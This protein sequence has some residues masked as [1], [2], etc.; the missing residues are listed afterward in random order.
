MSKQRVPFWKRITISTLLF[1]FS[2]SAVS[3]ATPQVA[4][5]QAPVVDLF[6]LADRLEDFIKEGIITA[7][8]VGIKNALRS[9]L[10][11]VAYDTATWIASGD[12]NQKPLLFTKDVGVYLEEAGDAATGEFLN[13]LA[14]KNGLVELNLCDLPEVEKL[15]FKLILPKLLG[16][17][18]YKPQCTFSE[19]KQEFTDFK[20]QAVAFMENPESLFDFSVSLDTGGNALSSLLSATDQ[21][22]GAETAAERAATIQRLKSDAKDKEAKVSEYIQT[23][24][25]VVEAQLEAA[26]DKSTDGETIQQ[27]NI[28]ADAVSVFFNTLSS[29]LME[30][31]TS[32]LL[33]FVTESDIADS[34]S[35]G[36]S[37]AGG[38]G[39][40]KG[41]QEKFASFRKPA[42]TTGGEVD[43]LTH[44]VNCPDVGTDVT[45]CIINENFRIAIE[46]ELTV[47][48]AIAQGLLDPSAI[49][50]GGVPNETIVDDPKSGLSVRALKVLKYYNVV[51]VGWLLA[52]E[53]NRD[54]D[55]TSLT[56]QK[57]L[58]AYDQ[59]DETN[60][61]PYCGLVDGDWV[62]KAPETFC[63]VQGYGE[64]IANEV[65]YEDLDGNK[66]TPAEP[67]LTR[68]TSCLDPQ[69]CLTEDENGSCQ[70]Y[71]YCTKQEDIYRFE[72]DSCPIYAASCEQFRTQ[73]NETVSYLKN[74]LNYND[75]T[76]DN[77]GCQWYCSITDKN[78]NPACIDQDTSYQICNSASGCSCST[79][80]E[81]CTVEEGNFSC[82]TG[83]GAICNLP[84]Q[85]QSGDVDVA[86]SFDRDV[87][88]C[89]EDEEGCTEFVSVK[90]GNM[91]W[92]GSFEHFNSH[93]SATPDAID[94][95]SGV[96]ES[97]TDGPYD[98]T[99]G[100][101][102]ADGNG[103]PCKTRSANG[104]PC[105]GWELGNG[106]DG[107][108]VSSS[109]FGSTGF[110]FEP[111]TSSGTLSTFVETGEPLANRTFSFSFSSL[112]PTSSACT[113]NLFI[114]PKGGTGNATSITYQP[115]T[116][117]TNYPGKIVTFPDSES[118]TAVE[119][120]M[121][122]PTNN[123]NLVID[124][125]TLI[126]STA[127]ASYTDYGA[128]KTYLNVE[129]T[130]QC[131][132]EQIGCELFTPRT[133]ESDIPVPAKITNPYSDVCGNGSDFTNPA[134]SQCTLE[135]LG[136]DAYIESPMPFAAPVNNIA[137]FQAL[138]ITV[139]A[140]VEDA[141]AGRTGLY[142]EGTSN[143][144]SAN[145]D[146]GADSAGNQIQCVPSISII[147]ET[148]TECSAA[149]VG[150]EE[151]VNLEAQAGGGEQLEHYTYIRQCVKPID[152][153]IEY[154]YTFEGSDI[155]GYQIRSWNLKKSNLTTGGPCTNLDLYGPTAQTATANCVDTSSNV[156]ACGIDTPNDASDD[157]GVNPDCNEYF[158][159]SG[160]VFHRLRSATVTV[161]D[162][163]TALR[164]TRDGLTYYVNPA[165]STSCPASAN[166]CREYKGSQGGNV[167]V[168]I[169][170]NFDK[171]VWQGGQSSSDVITAS[172]GQSMAVGTSTQTSS[173][174]AKFTV[175]TKV[176]ANDSYIL[177]F[178]AKRNAAD[179]GNSAVVTPS[180]FSPT[181]ATDKPWQTVTVGTEWQ[182]YNVGPFIFSADKAPEAAEEFRLQYTGSLVVIDNLELQRNSSHYLIQGSSKMCNGFEG[183][184]RYETSTGKTEYLKSFA[185]LCEESAVGCTALFDTQNSN[186]PYYQEF[187]TNNEH[188]IDDVKVS[189]DTPVA[190]VVKKDALCSSE[191]AGCGVYGR[192]DLDAS[193]A[194]QSYEVSYLINDPDSYNTI[195]C[196]EQQRDCEVFTT[197]SGT[198]QYFK[199]PGDKTCSYN[200]SSG[201]WE[202]PDGSE[203]P[204]QNPQDNPSQPKGSVC[205]G[206]TRDAQMCSS[207]ADCPS[208]GSGTIPRCSSSVNDQSGWVGSC[209]PEYAGCSLYMDPNTDSLLENGSFEVD[210]KDNDD[211]VAAAPDGIPDEW[212]PNNEN[213]AEG[214]TTNNFYAASQQ[215]ASSC[216]IA[217]IESTNSLV[218]EGSHSMKLQATG[219][220]CFLFSDLIVIDPNKTY[221]LTG[222]VNVSSSSTPFAIGLI[223]YNTS[224]T[225]LEAGTDTVEDYAI[226]AYEGGS[227][228]SNAVLNQ[229]ARF[230]ANIGPNLNHSF[231]AGANYVRVFIETADTSRPLYA[232][233]VTF[234][235]QKEYTYISSTVDGAPQS[236]QNS[237]NG[238]VDPGNGCVA[239]R[240]TTDTS[241]TS[242]ST[243]ESE[244]ANL[245]ADGTAFALTACQFNSSDP[246]QSCDSRVN[247]ADTNVVIKVR[248][249]R[250]CSEWLS[251]S[252]T[253]VEYDSNGNIASSTC[254][255]VQLCTQRNEDTGVCTEWVAKPAA[256]T[257][258]Y[259]DD[260]T[261][262][263]SPQDT[264][265]LASIRDLS[266]YSN[267]GVEW[268][269]LGCEA[270]FCL[271]GEKHGQ[272]CSTDP[273]C[274]TTAAIMLGYYPADWMPE[275]GLAGGATLTDLIADGDFEQ[276]LCDGSVPTGAYSD[277]E[278]TRDESLFCT[279]DS[280][281][282][283]FE[284]DREAQDMGVGSA[285][286]SEGWCNNV[287]SDGKWSDW[288]RYSASGDPATYLSVI[289][290][291]PDFSY[292]ADVNDGSGVS[293]GG[294]SKI[295]LNNVMY[296]L[297][298]GNAT[299]EGIK[300]DLGTDN[301]IRGEEY[302]ISFDAQYRSQPGETDHITVGFSYGD[303]GE[304]DV[305]EYGQALADIV[306]LIDVSG[307][308][309]AY[310]SSV[311][312]NLSAFAEGLEAQGINARFSIVTI[313][314][315]R[316]PHVLD[317]ADYT[318]ASSAFGASN[319][320]TTAFSSNVTTV[321]DVLTYLTTHLVSGA[322]ENYNAIK[323]VSDNSFAYR[324]VVA[325]SGAASPYSLPFRTEAER[326]AILVTDTVPEGEDP[327]I[328]QG[329]VDTWD[330]ADEDAFN[331]LLSADAL[332]LYAIT[333]SSSKAYDR[334]VAQLGDTS[335]Y[336][337]SDSN[338]N[339]LLAD[340]QTNIVQKTD[341]FQFST[342]YEQYVLG[343]IVVTNKPLTSANTYLYIAQTSGSGNIPFVIDNV[344]LKPALEVNKEGNPNSTRSTWL[345]GQQCRAYPE[346]SS[347]SC[348]YKTPEGVFY[349]GWKGY[350]LDADSSD[351]DKCIAWW[352]V[353]IIAGEENTTS[354]RIP[355]TYDQQVPAYHCLVA[356][357]NAD[358]GVC[359]NADQSGTGNGDGTDTGSGLMCSNNADCASGETCLGKTDSNYSF[360]LGYSAEAPS[361][362]LANL[363]QTLTTHDYKIVH[364]ID[365]I[366]V[367]LDGAQD[368]SENDGNQDY[369]WFGRIPANKLEQSVHISEIDHVTF[370]EGNIYSGSK[371]AP[372]EIGVTGY[373]TMELED[374]DTQ[375]SLW[376]TGQG[377]ETGDATYP[378]NYSYQ[379]GVWCDQ[380]KSTGGFC[381]KSNLTPSSLNNVDFIFSKAVSAAQR[382]DK[383]TIKYS[384]YDELYKQGV[385]YNIFAK[386]SLFNG[387]SLT[388]ETSPIWKCHGEIAE[389]ERDDEQQNNIVDCNN[390]GEWTGSPDF[391]FSSYWN[392]EAQADGG[393][394]DDNKDNCGANIIISRL[395]FDGGYLKNIYFGL[396]N[397]MTHYDVTEWRDVK[398][399]FHLKEP[400]LFLVESAVESNDNVK[401]TPWLS[402][403]NGNG[404]VLPSVNYT[405]Q[406]AH[407][408]GAV[409][410][411]RVFGVFGKTG[412]Y[413]QDEDGDRSNFDSA[414][415][416]YDFTAVA[417]NVP[418]V[419]LRSD[420]TSVT[421]Y[422]CIGSCNAIV[423]EGQPDLEYSKDTASQCDSGEWIGFSGVCSNTDENKNAVVCDSNSDC[424]GFGGTCVG[425]EGTSTASA[426]S[427]D[428][429]EFAALPPPE[430]DESDICNTYS[431]EQKTQ[432]QD[433]FDGDEKACD[434][435]DDPSSAACT[436]TESSTTTGLLSNGGVGNGSYTE[437][438]KAAAQAAWARYRLLFADVQSKVYYAPAS[439][440]TDVKPRLSLQDA[441]TSDFAEI[442]SQDGDSLSDFSEMTQCSVDNQTG[443]NYCGILPEVKDIRVNGFTD[444]QIEVN[445]GSSVTLT[446]DS[447][448]DSDQ[449]PLTTIGLVWEG[450]PTGDFLDEN[451]KQWP[452]EAAPIND[453]TYTHVYTCD[454]TVA[455]NN[456]QADVLTDEQGNKIG[457]CV[458]TIKVQIQDNWGFCSGDDNEG[459][460]GYKNRAVGGDRCTSYDSYSRQIYVRFP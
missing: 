114:Q 384:S 126:E 70:A 397:G 147:P 192:P 138:G 243:T 284:S 454:P 156:K 410:S 42:F 393:C 80:G 176:N 207:D 308:M 116:T 66:N 405:F 400:C 199:N 387:D 92:N 365:T 275:R 197:D 170:D 135:Y 268:E 355:V 446:F 391:H 314:A 236:D 185:S 298:T 71:G 153:E 67:L 319:G 78:G 337:I 422:S 389:P 377:T 44:F 324:D 367:D 404:Y 341:S 53:Y 35:G 117:F 257:L 434:C 282:R 38:S 43:I 181:T 222:H 106:L 318:T 376:K 250:Q 155:S 317:F 420:E 27:D 21:A 244:T 329:T 90:A 65:Q 22:I 198:E 129:K 10:E 264:G 127:I 15:Q 287:N 158:D 200:S 344:S 457:A 259:S 403:V 304:T 166:M 354:T 263:S 195:L 45:N 218:F 325:T 299:E 220:H 279:V 189:V 449:Q 294:T 402:R 145:S 415:D 137:A 16:K 256:E 348:D 238:T 438:L 96:N 340:I 217:S 105:Y 232:D 159:A 458:Y 184:E 62:L 63:R 278:S 177:S 261:I 428:Q 5:A 321:K 87:K 34:L 163:C 332:T 406:L 98:D 46:E 82:S 24:A 125:V 234:T 25:F 265:E 191:F 379:M 366:K 133:G 271:G 345:L 291:D 237:C 101:F 427:T 55:T 413:P 295:N 399:T 215:G 371:K 28:V 342:N 334:T 326:F 210:A 433:C 333:N 286:Y 84:T 164:N 437:Q 173:T 439:D 401:A 425:M 144:C 120:V 435:Y 178:W 450:T 320:I 216:S 416:L 285:D 94:E 351:P 39:G 296:V 227:R 343:P 9:F 186:L 451:P 57:A 239:F 108:A 247:T 93:T 49:I 68:L 131:E 228:S 328:D 115:G 306:L 148:G 443:T 361:T 246:N 313:G 72:G 30:R 233:G 276:V 136:C 182:Q 100:F 373:D 140:Q 254:A 212:S 205:V 142:C 383:T 448:V 47:H 408:N 392:S 175:G 309:G 272:Q 213:V 357:G 146:C 388:S 149:N 8:K 132:V 390:N 269:T 12:K 179:S 349:N 407:P 374:T 91:L 350:C 37:T 394:V 369:A 219:A 235:E 270:G 29:K 109:V 398:W 255:E 423:C 305:F 221:T 150:C 56:L 300:V 444:T 230:S 363:V 162:E 190:Y 193:G 41:A 431:G 134:C 231:P 311:A 85:N 23:P 307:S 3:V 312:A 353:D 429:S 209:A 322:A 33:N 346:S 14:T 194:V 26:I 196:Q 75:C 421:P 330:Q 260:Q 362:T 336:N 409:A 432:C 359:S 187:N 288:S 368:G 445:N 395:D 460:S 83:S 202:K 36:S 224:G 289:D 442:F 266:G 18:P 50:L 154:F 76:T 89:D 104:A 48:Q 229:W 6:A 208:D 59:C 81:S 267:I 77:A 358:L 103:A 118:R 20:D 123:C 31:F 356:K 174:Q 386:G 122:S 172:N 168:V 352:P 226:A 411:N 110:Q 316:E 290:Y 225:E 274:G 161:T 339:Q 88:P 370:H 302:V 19:M 424:A 211:P 297:P 430:E 157:I 203:C 436:G 40:V 102:G 241:L 119:V 292:E 58:A 249:D 167:E 160:N 32:G 338:Y 396:W 303:T 323:Q 331:P 385:P 414:P 74:T 139:T 201:R 141:I 17:E 327:Y 60:Y 79:S 335:I 54:F 281:C 143:S 258:G 315:N 310:I 69:T 7:G 381:S 151:Y 128:T 380:T 251:C 456:Y 280:H 204:V 453:H 293:T 2:I 165:E 418:T 113:N 206:G 111:T 375:Y 64:V 426:Q 262:T 252:N 169:A 301:I 4:Y 452:W 13:S 61:S 419:Y 253:S 86:I 95:L 183:C 248:N 440:S 99:F 245:A 51:P 121:T 124:G 52:G 455:S 277:L 11:K 242:L 283:T 171:G 112:N 360:K 459:Q 240:E 1:V 347:L 107:R 273:D 441:P 73:N 372:Y 180:F 223:Y 382:E 188:A 412:K 214:S 152:D 378:L 364:E 97:T 417:T 130:T 447:T